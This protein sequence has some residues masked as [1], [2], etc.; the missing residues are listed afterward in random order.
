MD[1]LWVV[2]MR[3]GDI[4]YDINKPSLLDP[5]TEIEPNN[6]LNMLSKM[7]I[8][9]IRYGEVLLNSHYLVSMYQAEIN[10]DMII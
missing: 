9:D 3:N 8:N 7:R 2:K 4:F 1:K 5:D 10:T 6:I